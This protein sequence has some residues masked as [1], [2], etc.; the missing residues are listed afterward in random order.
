[1]MILSDKKS[2]STNRVWRMRLPSRK[3]LPTNCFLIVSTTCVRFRNGKNS[4]FR[5]HEKYSWT[6]RISITMTTF[7]QKRRFAQFFSERYLPN[8][9]ILATSCVLI[10]FSIVMG[11]RSEKIP[12]QTL[13]VSRRSYLRFCW[14]FSD[15]SMAC[16]DTADNQGERS[17]GA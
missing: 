3:I 14:A 7:S 17:E 4:C 13:T 9:K 11:F 2:D 5:S 12:D 16:S 6:Q 1:M 8:R 10:L 15:W